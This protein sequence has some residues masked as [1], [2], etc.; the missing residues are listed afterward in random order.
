MFEKKIGDLRFSGSGA[1]R[2]YVLAHC[3]CPPPKKQTKNIAIQK[4]ALLD[5]PRP[6]IKRKKSLINVLEEENQILSRK[7]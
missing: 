4:P 1:Y 2:G 7:T 5:P 6:T 3:S